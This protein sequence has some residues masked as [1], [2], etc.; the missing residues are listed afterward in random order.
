MTLCSTQKCNNHN[1]IFNISL[2][3]K[4]RVYVFPASLS[5]LESTASELTTALLVLALALALKWNAILG[6]KCYQ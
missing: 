3:H 6:F 2:R 4:I 5:Y 1:L